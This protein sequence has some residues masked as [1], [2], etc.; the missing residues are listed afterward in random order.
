[1]PVDVLVVPLALVALTYALAWNGWGLLLTTTI[2]YLG[3][4]H[5][6]RQN[7][8]IARY[9]QRRAGGPVSAAHRPL[10]SMAFYLPMLAGVAY[11]TSTAPLHEG[12]AFHGLALDPGILWGLGAAA[13]AGV[14]AYLAWTTGRTAAG[15]GSPGI[16]R[17]CTAV[18]VHPGERWLVLANAVA[19]GSA[20]VL[21][22]WSASFILVLAIHHEVQYLYF[23]YAVGRRAEASPGRGATVELRRLARFAVWPL[24]GLAS[25]AVCTYSGAEALAPFLTAGLLG[26]YWLDGRIWTARARRLDDQLDQRDRRGS[27]DQA[28]RF[29]ETSVARNGRRRR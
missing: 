9:Y 16:A 4:W 24:I 22:A 10:L 1:M 8:G 28:D 14:L 25:W 3:A 2:L 21:G 19:F 17:G 23:T 6:G 11:Y 7:L 15:D 26:H 20:Y 18:A 5:R 29:A 12:D 27:T 13:A